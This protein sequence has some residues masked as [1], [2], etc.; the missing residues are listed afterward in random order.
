MPPKDEAASPPATPSQPAADDDAAPHRHHKDESARGRAHRLFLPLAEKARS[1]SIVIQNV[2]PQVNCGRYPVK[3]EV[4]DTLHVTAEIFR[5]GHDKLSAVI[6]YRRISES[7]WRESPMREV[8]FGL[9]EWAG[10]IALYENARYLFTVEAWTDLFASWCDEVEKKLGAGQNVH[11]ELVEGRELVEEAAARAQGDDAKRLQAVLDAFKALDDGAR[12]SLLLGQDVRAMMAR[13]PDR[14]TAIRYDK[15]LEVMVDRLQA[16]YAAW[17]EMFPRSQGQIPG[18]SATFADCEARLP[19]VRRMGFDVVYFVPIHPIGR[20]FRK[21]RNNTLNAGPDDPGSPYAIG[22]PEGGHTAIHPELGTLEDFRRFVAACHAQGMEVALDFAVQCSPDHPWIKDHPEWFLFRADGSIKY[23]ENPPKKYQ[24]IVNVDFYCTD[25]QSLWEELLF[26]VNFWVDQGVKIFRVDNPHTKPVPFWEWL[27]REVQEKHPD[28]IFLAEAFTRPPMLKMMAKIGFG[29]SYTYFTW[30][31]GK[32]ELTEYLTE[33]TQTD[34]KEYLRPNFFTN[35]PDINPPYLQTGGRPA[36]QIR[37]V[38]AATLSSVY[39]MYNGF[40]LCE[41]TPIPGKEEYL[42]SEK[43]EYKVWD[44]DQPG[45]I[46]DYITRINQIR[47][48]NPALHELD[49]LR[50]YPSTSDNILFYGKMTPDRR[51]MLFIAVN[52]DPFVANDGFVSFPLEEMGL[53]PRDRFIAEELFSFRRLEWQGAKHW[54]R[55][56]PYVNPC[57]IFRITRIGDVGW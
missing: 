8:N 12:A 33:L 13:W 57:E 26:V 10:S 35:T 2:Q 55:L 17:Y 21:G 11:L 34:V 28:V 39:G 23:A 48:D 15:E 20:T 32:Q 1:R 38:L 6:L 14:S 7:Q 36:H 45:N 53:G 50:F 9:A 42:N 24:D 30:R 3:R 29:Q 43:Y 46:K 56:D 27:I 49:N 37:L 41:A 5:E 47:R 22:G 40:E 51:N 19:E 31:H 16:R 54:I 4:G 52:L 25:W 18:R 44:W